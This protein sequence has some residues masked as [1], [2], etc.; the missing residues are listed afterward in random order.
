MT[1]MAERS[2]L[3]WVLGQVS[4]LMGGWAEA[5]VLAMSQRGYNSAGGNLR[6]KNARV[7]TG[8]P[9]R[10]WASAI[11]VH[12]GRIAGFDA[13][14]GAGR[15]IDAAGRLVVPGFQENHLHPQTPFVLFSPSAPM[16]FRCTS[17]D[18]VLAK[19]RKYVADYDEDA[20]PRLFGWM[21]A[22]FKN[23]EKPTRARLDAATAGRPCYLVHHSGHEFW[24]NTKAL[25]LAGAL[26]A[27]PPGLPKNCVIERDPATGLLPA[28]SRN[29]SSPTPMACCCAR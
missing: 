28:I 20:F 25:E 1:T 19:V 2:T 4:A 29:L 23:G 26:E 17:V 10:P 12:N 21:S 27:D 6:V 7:W 3:D 5:A 16:L 18:E 15:T 22:I 14:E 11:V 8:D 24:A 9:L 13:A